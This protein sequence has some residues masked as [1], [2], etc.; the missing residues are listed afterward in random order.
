MTIVDCQEIKW[1]GVAG[2]L[3]A[4]SS[5]AAEQLNHEQIGQQQQESKGGVDGVLL[6]P[7]QLQKLNIQALPE[8]SL[9]S[10]SL[11]GGN[12]GGGLQ[13]L[14]SLQFLTIWD[15]PK[16]LH[17]YSYSNIP[18]PT[19]LQILILSGCGEFRGKG[20]GPLLAQGHLTSLSILKTPNFFVGSEPLDKE[21]LPCSSA[22][23]E[24][25][26]K[27]DDIARL[28]SLET[29]WIGSC[30]VM[31]SLPEDGLPSSL[32][33]LVIGDCPAIKLLPKG[34]LPSSLQVLDIWYCL[35]LVS[36]PKNG[37]PSSLQKL[38][39]W[40][41][42]ALKSLPEDG[43][44]RSLQEITIRGSTAINSLPKGGL[45]RSLQ[46]LDVHYCD[47]EEL[48]RNCPCPDHL[49]FG[50]AFPCYQG[51]VSFS[52][53][54]FYLS[55]HIW[56]TRLVWYLSVHKSVSLEWP[57]CFNVPCTSVL[58]LVCSS[59]LLESKNVSKLPMEAFRCTPFAKVH[60]SEKLMSNLIPKKRFSVTEQQLR[61][62]AFRIW[63][64]AEVGKVDA[65]LTCYSLI[66]SISPQVEFGGATLRCGEYFTVCKIGDFPKGEHGFSEDCDRGPVV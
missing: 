64:D 3:S 62:T 20:I 17:S 28:A 40:N 58:Q 16:L 23:Q 39:I 24:L 31:R 21:L 5:A 42:P 65:K 52:L 57:S 33:K 32:K 47:N 56:R 2:Q 34:S 36:L 14:R 43:L 6:L 49:F 25:E 38:E 29:L 41:C 37:L 26:L 63:V 48:K 4:S 35:A 46:V 13:G 53:V 54:D 61:H 12:E 7:P 8:L 51:S 66:N 10:Y 9:L 11:E 60:V 19:S 27:T 50:Y 44:P 18:F 55:M 59:S 22:H 30:Q 1:L 15:C 45:P